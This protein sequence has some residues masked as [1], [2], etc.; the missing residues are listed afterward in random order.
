MKFHAPDCFFLSPR[1]RELLIQLCSSQ[2]PFRRHIWCSNSQVRLTRIRIPDHSTERTSTFSVSLLKYIFLFPPSLSS[3]LSS[4]TS[5]HP[6]ISLRLLFFNTSIQHITSLH[7]PQQTSS[8]NKHNPHRQKAIMSDAPDS[9][10]TAGETKLLISII[11]NLTGD[12]QV[13]LLSL[14]YASDITAF[15]FHIA[16]FGCVLFSNAVILSPPLHFL[17]YASSGRLNVALH[18]PCSMLHM[19][20]SSP[21]LLFGP[22]P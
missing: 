17:P 14:L 16:T 20:I 4:Q 1:N 18:I 15:S 12:L 9:T 7:Y 13:C 2:Q 8:T 19:H 22:P 21:S 10:F 5:I 11:K 3:F 6:R